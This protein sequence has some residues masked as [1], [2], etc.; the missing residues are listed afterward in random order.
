MKDFED[1]TPA[2]KEAARYVLP[3]ARGMA[4]RGP[5]GRLSSTLRAGSEPGS[6]ESRLPYAGPIHWG[7]QERNI[8]PNMFILEAMRRAEPQWLKFFEKFSQT[9]LDKV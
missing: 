4:P 9:A 3:L 7:W 8:E 1:L 5:T 2:Q 6:V